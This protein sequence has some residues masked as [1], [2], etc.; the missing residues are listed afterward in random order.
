MV[1][2]DPVNPSLLVREAL[3]EEFRYLDI[4]HGYF[5]VEPATAAFLRAI[6]SA[7][8]RRTSRLS[9]LD[10]RLTACHGA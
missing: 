5:G 9:Y 1:D 4:S 2:I 10:D 8:T 7:S 3:E 6:S